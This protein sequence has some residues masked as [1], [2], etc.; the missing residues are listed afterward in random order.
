MCVQFTEKA[1][2]GSLIS[3][4]ENQPHREWET[5]DSALALSTTSFVTLE[6]SL[7]SIPYDC[8]QF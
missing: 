3:Q 2:E 6:R 1:L 4:E 5:L 7:L 8:C